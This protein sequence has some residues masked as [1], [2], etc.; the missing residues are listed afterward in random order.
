MTSWWQI[1]SFLLWNKLRQ[2]FFSLP[3][4]Q[5]LNCVWSVPVLT[6]REP[7]IVGF[8][9]G[10]GHLQCRGAF[11]GLWDPPRDVGSS[12]GC[13]TL[14]GLWDPPGAVGPSGLWDPPGAVG[15]SRCCGALPGP[16][17]AAQGRFTGPR[18]C[19]ACLEVQAQ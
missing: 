10:L 17:A 18:M 8:R 19:R 3:Y 2:L 4:F 9:A 5:L 11:E 12:Q 14:L 1:L 16:W 15:P 6:T 13:R 7:L